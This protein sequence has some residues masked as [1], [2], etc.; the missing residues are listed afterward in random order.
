MTPA[1]QNSYAQLSLPS[2]CS[3]P[4]HRYH[5]YHYFGHY[6]SVVIWLWWLS[7]CGH[8][9]ICDVL[10]SLSYCGHFLSVVTLCYCG[11][12]IVYLSLFTCSFVMFSCFFHFVRRFW[13]QIFTWVKSSDL[14]YL[15]EKRQQQQRNK[16]HL[17]MSSPV[18]LRRP[19]AWNRNWV[20]IFFVFLLLWTRVVPG[21]IYVTLQYNIIAI[22]SDPLFSNY[23]TAKND[24]GLIIQ[25]RVILKLAY[26]WSEKV[27][28]GIQEC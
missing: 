21:T 4:G 9:I 25:W 5:L 17:K 22:E 15:K 18:A 13:N 11:H 3:L 20:E 12:L 24:Q 27:K 19:I 28:L 23:H 7:E 6:L 16:Q 10:W 8:P 2:V 1:L 14:L 26:S